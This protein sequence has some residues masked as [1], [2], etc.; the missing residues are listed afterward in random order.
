MAY[1]TVTD[2]KVHIH[3]MNETI[4]M[5][6]EGLETV[7]KMGGEGG[8]GVVHCLFR[9][10]TLFYSTKKVTKTRQNKPS[11]RT[12]LSTSG[13]SLHKDRQ[14][15][16]WHPSLIRILELQTTLWPSAW[17]HHIFVVGLLP[18]RIPCVH[19]ASSWCH[20]RDGWDQVF[21]IFRTLPLPCIIL[22]ANRRTINGGGLG[23]WLSELQVQGHIGSYHGHQYIHTRFCALYQVKKL[24]H[25]LFES[26]FWLCWLQV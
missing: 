16:S 6:G 18:L 23:T 7:R 11:P 8:W 15:F 26:Q 12:R 19:L 22:N 20:T 24:L 17:L 9:G 13:D 3:T 4:K 25:W 1:E 14:A 10:F 2:D 21:P 5:R